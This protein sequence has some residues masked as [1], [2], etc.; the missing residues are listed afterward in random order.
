MQEDPQQ[1]LQDVHQLFLDIQQAVAEA[2]QT[3][4][5]LREAQGQGVGVADMFEMQMLMNHFSQLSE[6]S[7]SVVQASNAAMLSMVRNVKG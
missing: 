2:A 6:M 7:T 5:E 1:K 3:L 4:Q